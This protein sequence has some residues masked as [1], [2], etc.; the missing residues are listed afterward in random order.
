MDY[1]S[2]F[3]WL[4]LLLLVGAMY[5]WSVTRPER[6]RAD[7]LRAW[8][9]THAY[10][11]ATPEAA[12]AW[13]RPSGSLPSLFT[14]GDGGRQVE[15]VIHGRRDG[16][17]LAVFDYEYRQVSLTG[18]SRRVRTRQQTVLVL[19]GIKGPATSWTL[20]PALLAEQSL[21][22]L[23]QSEIELG[24]EEFSAEYYL[25]GHPPEAIQARFGRRQRAFYRNQ[26]ALATE[27]ESG[28][29]WVYFPGRRVEGESQ[30]IEEFIALG[31]QLLD[32]LAS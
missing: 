27:Y 10:Q 30:K 21:Q 7:V 14:L 32:L 2:L 8:A 1:A 31:W 20:W 18:F 29:L 23:S 22:A 9:Q 25:F 26:A 17:A 16:V 5:Y 28:R 13:L 3:T 12:A 19:D 4:A 11:L 6:Q 15:P 24:D